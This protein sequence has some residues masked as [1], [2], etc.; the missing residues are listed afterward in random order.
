M[1]SK[2][3]MLLACPHCDKQAEIVIEVTG[4]AGSNRVAINKSRDFTDFFSFTP[5]Q[6]L[7]IHNDLVWR[8]IWCPTCA[9]YF[10]PTFVSTGD[11]TI[12]ERMRKIVGLLYGGE[13][14][15][16]PSPLGG[17]DEVL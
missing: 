11:A 13:D 9:M 14:E 17:T 4:E 15:K 1:K 16:E 12:D 3:Q 10:T 2:V 8:E 7:E 6:L 5:L